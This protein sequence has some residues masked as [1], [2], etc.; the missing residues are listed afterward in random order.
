MARILITPGL[1][2]DESEIGESFILSSGPG[3]QNVNKVA[4]AVQLRFDAAHSPGL[5]TEIK[6]RL[7]TLAGQRMTKEGVVVITARAGRSQEQNRAD[8]RSRL[9]SLLRAASVRPKSRVATK[10]SRSAKKK[11]FD[12]KQKHGVLKKLRGKP[13][14]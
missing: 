14:W 1:S 11:R 3:G 4:S 7:R 9:L 12:K 6:A 5:T 13:E 2:I 10:P 8:A